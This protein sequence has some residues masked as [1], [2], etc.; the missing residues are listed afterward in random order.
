[1]TSPR[2]F[3]S[4]WQVEQTPGGFK[5]LDAN[6]QARIETVR[7]GSSLTP[8]VARERPDTESRN[9]RLGGRGLRSAPFLV[10]HCLGTRDASRKQKKPRHKGEAS[11]VPSNSPEI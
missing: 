3:P 6:A 5:V 1:M 10:S 8:Y 2:R 7:R 4:P 9:T 11:P